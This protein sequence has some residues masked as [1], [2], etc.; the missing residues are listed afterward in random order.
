MKKMIDMK[1]PDATLYPILNGFEP[2][3]LKRC[4]E[5]LPAIKPEKLAMKPMV[6]SQS[7]VEVPPE[8]ENVEQA[9]LRLKALYLKYKITLVHDLLG[10][11]HNKNARNALVS[12]LLRD[13]QLAQ[14][15]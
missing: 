14:M 1:V 13:E 7:T 10:N 12:R 11:I 2:D 4:M 3:L 8:P 9:F 15:R 5:R 6:V